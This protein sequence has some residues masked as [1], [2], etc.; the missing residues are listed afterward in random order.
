M[1]FPAIALAGTLLTSPGVATAETPT[2]AVGVRA[3]PE[4]RATV[5]IEMRNASEHA[6]DGLIHITL[7]LVPVSSIPGETCTRSI[8]STFFDLDTTTSYRPRQP[9]PPSSR[10]RLAVGGSRSVQVDLEQ[11]KWSLGAPLDTGT[12]YELWEVAECAEY[13][14]VVSAHLSAHPSDRAE[15]S[16]PWAS[17]AE[18]RPLRLRIAPR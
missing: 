8:L 7:R 18:S 15:A 4:T 2:L 9:D 12:V 16:P 5:D 11:L 6:I 17:P 1:T 10:L 3:V 13:R 14:F